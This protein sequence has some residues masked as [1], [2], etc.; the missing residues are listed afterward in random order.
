MRTTRD[1][2]FEWCSKHQKYRDKNIYSITLAA[3]LTIS[4]YIYS[5]KTNILSLFCPHV[6]D[7][8]AITESS[9]IA[10]ISVQP[11]LAKKKTEQELSDE[12]ERTVLSFNENLDA[13]DTKDLV[14]SLKVNGFEDFEEP[15]FLSTRFGKT[16][17]RLK[18]T[19]KMAAAKLIG[20]SLAV[21]NQS[22]P[23]PFLIDFQASLPANKRIEAAT[24]KQKT[25]ETRAIVNAFKN[26]KTSNDLAQIKSLQDQLTKMQIEQ[27]K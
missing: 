20:T 22:S 3:E 19:N 4:C 27:K 11:I 6:S 9:T 7:A 23:I 14:E 26:N 12:H 8:R 1:L 2:D 18:M 5:P 15:V 17:L 13:I 24:Q 16:Y 21:K 25:T 10:G